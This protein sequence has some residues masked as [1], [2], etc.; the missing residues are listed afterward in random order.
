MGAAA[1]IVDE[2]ERTGPLSQ[3]MM[4]F[5]DHL[6]QLL[7]EEFAAAWKEGRDAGSGVCE[8]LERAAAGTE[9]RRSDPGL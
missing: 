8:V 1:K 4:E 7:A 2:S 5:V 6:A 9:H 3:E